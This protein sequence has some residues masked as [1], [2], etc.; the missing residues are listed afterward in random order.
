MGARLGGLDNKHSSALGVNRHVL[1]RR[2]TGKTVDLTYMGV[3]PGSL[4]NQH[5]LSQ[6]GCELAP[7]GAPTHNKT[8]SSTQV[9]VV[10]LRQKREKITR[11]GAGAAGG[12]Q[13]KVGYRYDSE[14]LPLN[15][16]CE[17][18]VSS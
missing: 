1:G 7:P 12:W 18:L 17:A 10:P 13:G 5:T 2:P 8:G 11:R 15:I 14:G 16:S 4:D 6:I 9:G 3:E